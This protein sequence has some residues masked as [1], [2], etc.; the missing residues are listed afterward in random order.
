MN[1]LGLDLVSAF[2]ECGLEGIE[3]EEPELDDPEN[4]DDP[5]PKDDE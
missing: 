2:S 5:E 4:P 1:L 3:V